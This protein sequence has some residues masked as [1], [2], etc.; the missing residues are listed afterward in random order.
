[1]SV[2]QPLKLTMF[3]LLALALL[4]YGV[5]SINC[6]TVPS[7]ST[8][9]DALLHFR[10]IISDPRGSLSSWNTSMNYC[11]WSGVTCSPKH[12]G[13][14]MALELSGQGL[15]GPIS[16]SVGNLTFLRT[17]DLSFN[18]FSGD[19]P[20]LRNL[21]NMRVLNLSYNILGGT[22][23]DAITNCSNLILLDLFSNS[24]RGQI[25]IK[26]GFLPN[27]LYLVLSVNNLTG[28]IPPSLGN[29]THVKIIALAINDLTGSIPVE[30]VNMPNLSSLL[31]GHNKLSGG[32]PQTPLNLSSLERLFLEFNE[33]D[34]VLPPNIGD[35]LPKLRQLFLGDNMF[36][37]NIPA[38]L[39]NATSLYYIDLPFNNFTGQVPISF[40]ELSNLSTLNLGHNKLDTKGQGWEFLTA[41]RNCSFLKVLVLEQNQL[42]GTIP[43]SIGNLS[44]LQQ[45]FLND[46]ELSGAVP[47]SIGNLRGLIR[48]TLGDNSFSGTIKE[49]VGKLTNLQ[50]LLI[51][52]NDFM[53]PIPSSISNVTLL[54]RLYLSSNDFEGSIPPNL[55][56]LRHLELLDLSQN[57]LQ[58]NIPVEFGGLVQLVGLDLSSNRLTGGIPQALDQCINLDT[59][60]MGQNFLV[61]GIPD[62][63]GNLKSLAVLNLSHNNLTGTIPTSFSDLPLLTELDLSYNNLEGQIPKNGVF[64]NSTIVSVEGNRGLCG[65]A[66]DLNMPPCP[67]VSRSIQGRSYYLI[68]VLIPIFGLMSLVLLVYLLFLV[69]K[70]SRKTDLS[71]DYIGEIFPKVS[72]KDL[73]QATKNFSESNLIGRGSYGSVYRGKLKESDVEVAVKVFDLEMRDAERS[74][75]LECE[76]LRSIQHRNLLPIITACSTVDN[77]GNVFKALLYEFMPNGSLDEWLHHKGN[78]KSPKHLGL[79]TR[80]SIAVNIAD[81]LDYLHNDC[82]RPIVHCDLKPS[83]ILLNDDM[84]ALL[85][86][87]GIA[88]FYV[89]SCSASAGSVSSIGVKG[90]IGYI[91]PGILMIIFFFYVPVL[92]EKFYSIVYY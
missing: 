76:A 70:R 42:Q 47:P 36:E 44:S 84:T 72:Y 19:I 12:Q 18:Q 90:T 41:L 49:W 10:A 78:E 91:A 5:R 34:G 22:I 14:V 63:F 46:N 77:D 17:L 55:G 9:M 37:G 79:T 87:F 65:G 7:N 83:N 92:L 71:L 82:G 15:S 73:A 48:L 56:N 51:Q 67:S 33:L 61:G 6:A 60:E 24:L 59:I 85:G 68:R 39:G 32:I 86:D 57:N 45:L 4:S 50:G 89:E 38:S 27:L 1:M 30:L 53:G 13:R 64:G 43:S 20:P 2:N 54:Q 58:G 29:L 8:D 26:I 75:M 66:M 88:R 81:A 21:H 52:G 74:F 16:A 35:A 40:G 80:I 3:I 62:S 69:K 28:I 25:P 11:R 31:L 23:P